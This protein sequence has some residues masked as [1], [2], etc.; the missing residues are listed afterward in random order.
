[1]MA[2]VWLRHE[3]HGVKVAYL[4]AEALMDEKN[5]WERFNQRGESHAVDPVAAPSPSD[6]TTEAVKPRRG[7]P[8]KEQ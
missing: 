7:R 4:E 1:M 5:G 6:T 3:R 8:R 2:E